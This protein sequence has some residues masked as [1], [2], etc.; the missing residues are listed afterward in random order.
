MREKKRINDSGVKDRLVNAIQMGAPFKQ[1]CAYAGIHP[2][3]LRRWQRRAEDEVKR[4]EDPNE[5]PDEQESKYVDL[6]ERLQTAEGN[7]VVGLLAQIEKAA[8]EGTWQ[9]AAWKLE[10]RYPEDFSRRVLQI[11][12]DAEGGP[13]KHHHTWSD[14]IYATPHVDVL[15]LN[16]AESGQPDSP[17]LLEEIPK[18]SG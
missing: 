16:D 18:T 12:G 17:R 5:V 8:S 15:E 6:Y 4:L 2:E 7:S 13:V 14:I 3:S 9:A 10:R 11:Q 1:A